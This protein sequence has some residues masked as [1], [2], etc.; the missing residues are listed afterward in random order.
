MVK[1]KSE[2]D[3]HDFWCLPGGRIEENETPAEAAL[4]E[5]KEECHI[6]G[7]IV[8]EISVITNPSDSNIL[9]YDRLHTFI[10]D[11]GTQ[12]PE[13]G[14]DPE[15]EEGAILDVQ[16]LTLAEI[17]ERDRAYLWSGGLLGVQ[18][19]L[20]EVFIWGDSISYPNLKED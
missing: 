8:Q 6:D 20:D 1:L 19:F 5:L 7:T 13:I 11:A 9:F 18:E 3:G 15:L 4:R 10:I 2:E 12:E 14:T 16:W 17:P